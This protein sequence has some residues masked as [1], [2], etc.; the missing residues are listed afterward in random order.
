MKQALEILLDDR[1]QRIFD[2]F[3]AC[4]GIRIIYFT[5]EG[6]ELRVGL[7]Y[8]DS[9]YCVRAQEA[10]FGKATCL[11]LDA[12]KRAE[13][14]RLRRLLCYECHAGCREAVVPIYMEEVLLGFMMMGQFRARRR[15][16]AAVSDQCRSAACRRGL[17]EA[18]QALPYFPEEKIE[19]ILGLF[20]V[21]VDYIVAGSLI[22]LKGSL[23]VKA[24]CDHLQANVGRTPT[25]PEAAAMVN[26]SVSGVAHLFK[27]QV[28]RSYKQTLIEFKLQSAEQ[29]LRTHPE[30]RIREVAAKVGYQDPFLFSRI[31]RKHRGFPP[32]LFRSRLMTA[33]VAGLPQGVGAAAHEHA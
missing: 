25:L 23:A 32:S 15:M 31:Y 1:V 2:C 30:L 6:E 8:P 5:P 3:S 18:Y 20:R 21:L 14:T 24:I 22:T 17:D 28:G 12:V 11:Q 26:R 19:N 10:V 29:H 4:F 7:N 9:H 27:Q 33:D 16:P 13:A